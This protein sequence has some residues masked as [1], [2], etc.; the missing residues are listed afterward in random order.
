[1]TERSDVEPYERLA[2]LAEVE[3][4]LAREGALEQLLAVQRE[5]EALVLLLPAAPPPEATQALKQAA[6]FN[7]ATTELLG[8]AVAS[9]REVL[10]AIDRGQRAMDGYAPARPSRA[11]LDASA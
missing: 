5:R 3:L 1:M 7:A 11:R 6:A 4:G 8:V 9:R 10:T 2:A